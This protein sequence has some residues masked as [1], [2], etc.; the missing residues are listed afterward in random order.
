MFLQVGHQQRETPLRCGLEASRAEACLDQSVLAQLEDKSG[1]VAAHLEAPANQPD[2]IRDHGWRVQ[3]TCAVGQMG[4]Q[5][6]H[7]VVRGLEFEEG[8]LSQKMVQYLDDSCKVDTLVV[9]SLCNAF[10]KEG[11]VSL[12]EL[13]FER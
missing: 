4:R 1:S 10:Q 5:G 6:R 3:V 9:G 12:S 2:H 7:E 11:S 8:A 13:G